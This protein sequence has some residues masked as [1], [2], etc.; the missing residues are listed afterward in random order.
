MQQICS[1]DDTSKTIA[2]FNWIQDRVTYEPIK[3]KVRYKNVNMNRIKLK[4][5]KNIDKNDLKELWNK[6]SESKEIYTKEDPN[7]TKSMLSNLN[8][9]K[10]TNYQLNDS[11]NK[12]NLLMY[13][14]ERI[15]WED[16]WTSNS[17]DLFNMNNYWGTPRQTAYFGK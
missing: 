1:K 4:F 5:K 15:Q 16:L 9:S 6:D 13:A 3:I 11:S 10:L 8:M 14:S 2:P 7:I 17:K 12:Y